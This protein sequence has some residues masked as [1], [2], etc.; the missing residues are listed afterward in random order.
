MQARAPVALPCATTAGIG[1]CPSGDQWGGFAES[2]SCLGVEV[3]VL[4]GTCTTLSGSAGG[5]TVGGGVLGPKA[6]SG[7]SA[8]MALMVE[9]VAGSNASATTH[10][11]RFMDVPQTCYARPL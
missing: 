3:L 1:G 7:R 6:Q 5:A 4:P 10:T 11:S 2:S 9:V 8:A